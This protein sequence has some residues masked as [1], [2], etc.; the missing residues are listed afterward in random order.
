MGM[1]KLR[2]TEA[3]ELVCEEKQED[4]CVFVCLCVC[5]V[6]GEMEGSGGET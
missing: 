5:V 2:K 6:G 4:M 3:E 1:R